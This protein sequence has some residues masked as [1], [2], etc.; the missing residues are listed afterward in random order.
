MT[1]TTC[2][3]CG[4]E[5]EIGD[6]PFCPHESIYVQNA[7]GFSP[8]VV[9]KDANGKIR[10]PGSADAP[11]PP[12]FQRVELT[13]TAEVRRFEREVN[14]KEREKAGQNHASQA[15]I[16]ASERRD[17]REKFIE[18][19]KTFSKRGQQFAD[20]MMKARDM[21]RSRLERPV[22]DPNFHVEAFSQNSSNREQYN[23]RATGWRGRKH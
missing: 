21:H 4:H 7:Q 19:K 16:S 6:Y 1:Q 15:F 3:D 23:D 18:L 5:L 14:A 9:H 22:G 2:K 20:A 12:G 11:C 17:R 8:V 10:F 13:T